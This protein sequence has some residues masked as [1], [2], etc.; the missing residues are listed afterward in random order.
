MVLLL[1]A[2]TE[3][4][5]NW[6]LPGMFIAAVLSG[7]I[8]PFSSE[9]VLVALVKMGIN[10]TACVITATIGNTIGGL[11]CYY[12][13]RMGK[14]EWIEKYFKIKKE[15]LEKMEHFLRG[16]GALMGFFAFLPTIGEVM[17]VALGYMRSN[18]WLTT[19]S[20]LIGKLLRYIILV[21]L[22]LD[23]IKLF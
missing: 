1:S 8:F 17:A 5:T 11:T 14:I 15:K 19:I 22:F 7:S 10:P 16:K 21:L 12:T 20:M 13:G 2:A 9:V 4:L 23:I 6:G 18:I 3:Q